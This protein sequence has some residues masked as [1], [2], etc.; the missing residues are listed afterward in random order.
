VNGLRAARVHV[1]CRGRILRVSPGAVT[2]MRHVERLFSSLK[3][4][5]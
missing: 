5:V 4:Y 3:T 1:D 2:E